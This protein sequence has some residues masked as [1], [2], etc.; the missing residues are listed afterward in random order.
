MTETAASGL[1]VPALPAPARG[2]A[3]WIWGAYALALVWG[4]GLMGL[5]YGLLRRTGREALLET[6]RTVLRHD[7]FVLSE[8]LSRPDM[9]AAAGIVRRLAVEEGARYAVLQDAG[10]AAAV[11]AGDLD[12][13]R[14][15]GLS[16]AARSARDFQAV[17][18]ETRPS[19]LECQ[20]PLWVGSQKWGVLRWGVWTD[21][22]EEQ[23]R[24]HAGRLLAAWGWAALAGAAPVYIFWRTRD[25]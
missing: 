3:A 14:E 21:G 13:E 20:Q 1:A 6:S 5:T 9:E 23:A 10:G 19:Y 25:R 12:P 18:A 15:E 24:R 22:L 17:D 11:S 7:A 2:S 16:R 4:L 8:A